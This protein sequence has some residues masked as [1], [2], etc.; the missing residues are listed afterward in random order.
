VD[1]GWSWAA[2]ESARVYALSG[3]GAEAQR[4]LDELLA[5]SKRSHVSNY[6]LATVY[7]ALG[8]KKHALDRLEQA[9][10]ERSFFFDFLKSDPQMDSLRSE[11]RF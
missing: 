7:A 8:D 9:Y 2:A 10:S 6:L 4:G 5:L 1:T 11:P 3:R